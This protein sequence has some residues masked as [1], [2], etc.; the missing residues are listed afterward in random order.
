MHQ[1]F[2]DI[3]AEYENF[4]QVLIKLVEHLFLELYS[5]KMRFILL[6]YFLDFTINMSCII[7]IKKAELFY[8]W[9]VLSFLEFYIQTLII[10][11]VAI[12]LPNNLIFG[13]F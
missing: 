1:E 6:L 9:M 13:C 10:S 4:R 8:I 5:I 2:K 12:K 7:F 11:H 3:L